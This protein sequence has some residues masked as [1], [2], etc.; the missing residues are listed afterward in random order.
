MAFKA[1]TQILTDSGWKKVEDIAGKDKVL[2]RNFI[3]DAE[4]IQP[5]ALKKGKYNGEII[6]IGG[7]RWS[8]SVTPDHIIVYDRDTVP[9]GV[10]FVKK[11]AKELE[12]HPNNRIYRKFKYL[13]PED[14]KK[15]AIT[16]KDELG[17]RWITISPQDWYVLVGYVLTRGYLEPTTRRKYALNLR[18]NNDNLEKELNTLKDILDRIGVRYSVLP[19]RTTGTWF[20]RVNPQNGLAT[21]LAT[22]LGS[23]K[24]KEMFLP[25][26]M[27]FNAT[28]ELAHTL[29]ETIID[30]TKRPET[31]RGDF[32]QF[33]TNNESLVK[34]LELLGSL[35]GYGM[36]SRV[37]ARK[38]ED[39]GQGELK[40]DVYNLM[41]SQETKTY[42]PT[43]IEKSDYEGYVYSIDLFEG[44]VYVRED[45]APV[46]VNPK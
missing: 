1:G 39:K 12:I 11:P 24:R 25:D 21:R 33:T 27:I 38:G 45:K 40:K 6:K 18:L 32:Y 4:F 43:K 8:F 41:I 28:R 15:E 31:A 29:I 16:A 46:W 23:D 44:Q 34:S 17:K 37:M 19:N 36:Y 9:R 42:A 26:V 7:K 35:W 2:V 5:F 30:A 22:R 3:G 20:I 13:A 10:N 14:Y